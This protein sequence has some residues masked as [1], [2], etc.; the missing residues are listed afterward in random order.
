MEIIF[1]EEWLHSKIREEATAN[2]EFRQ[3][4]GSRTFK[5]LTRADVE[6]YQLFKLRKMLLHV[7]KNGSFY[8]ELFDTN[9]IKP[10]D[11]R[12]LA[13][14][15]RLP[16]TEPSDLAENPNR[17]LCVSHGDVARVTTFTTSGTTGP[18]KRVFYT[19]ADLDRITDFMGTGIRTV[20]NKGDVVHIMLPSGSVNNQA[21]L[22]ARG[23]EKIG[24]LPVKGGMNRS[25]DEQLELIRRHK[26]AVLF[27]VTP[28]M[29]SMTQELKTKCALDSLGI[30]TLFV[31]SGYLSEPMRHHMCELWKADVHVHYGLTEMGLGV[32]V[33]CHA[34]NGFH[35][36]E[37]DLLLEVVD[38]WT[39]QRVTEGEGELVFTT[40]NREGTPLI[41]YR[42]HDIAALIQE[43][44]PCG[45]STLLKFGKV[46]RRTESLVK[47]G[48]GGGTLPHP[49]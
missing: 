13:D 43:A 39:G 46:T 30:K 47:I 34:H 32:A 4:L 37:V 19:D 20:A 7:Y 5:T 14:L 6:E 42:T 29:Y 11:I 40:L 10:A 1:L 49:F 18:Q 25:A 2:Q 41:R 24:A 8:R 48:E 36:N 17:F 9:G 27:G 26:P 21:D 31:T 44:C 16:F 28:R 33:E 22:L 35:F 3:F 12:S 23:I 45:A 15:S 38:P